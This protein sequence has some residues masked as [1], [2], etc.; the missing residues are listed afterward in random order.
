MYKRQV[1]NTRETEIGVFI[2]FDWKNFNNGKDT[3]AINIDRKNGTII[4]SAV[5]RPAKIIIKPLIVNI[6]L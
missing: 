1:I 6:P 4:L 3:R 2:F 5:L